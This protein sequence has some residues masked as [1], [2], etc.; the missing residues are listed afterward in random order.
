MAVSDY[1][2]QYADAG[3]QYGVDPQL[4]M[5]Q[6][7]A[8]SS[9]DINA[10]GADTKYGNAEG[11]A[12]LIPDTAKRLGVTNPKDPTQAIP[13]QAKLM[14][15][16]LDRYGNVE[17][18]LKAYHG[19][20]NQSNWGPV[21]HAYPAKVLKNY[22]G[23]QQMASND[24]ENDPL[25]QALLD[26]AEA[27]KTK[28]AG[29]N[30]PLKITIPNLKDHQENDPLTQALLDS[31]EEDKNKPPQNTNNKSKIGAA[32]DLAETIPSSVV[33]AIGAVP[34]IP[35][36]AGNTVANAAGY[37]YGKL[38]GATPEQQ[39]KLNTLNPFFTGNTPLDAL[40]QSEGAIVNNNPGPANPLTGGVLH[41]PETT[42]GRYANAL[43]QGAVIGP[44]A[45]AR[46]IPSLTGAAGAQTASEIAP[47]NPLAPLVG[48]LA[49]GVGPSASKSLEL[50]SPPEELANNALR[51]ATDQ[52]PATLAPNNLTSSE[53]VP[54]SK[55]TLAQVTND[56]N[57]AVIERQLQAKNPAAFKTVEDTNENARQQYFQHASGTPEDIEA[58]QNQREQATT[59]LYDQARI[60]PLNKEAISPILSKI[61]SAVE[62]VGDG[63]DAG[64]TLLAIKKKIEGALPSDI[65]TE[66]GT[67]TRNPTQSPLIQIYREERDN[68][69]KPSTAEGA[70]AATVKS[71][72]KPIISSLGDAIE[73]QSEPFAK[74]QQTYREISP[75]IDAAQWLQGLK[76]TD[77]TGRFT[78][79]K[80]NNALQNAQR[81]QSSNGL[82]SAKNLTSEQMTTLTN[83]RDDL[84]RRENVA[85]ASMPRG[86]N[87]AQNL[88]SSPKGG[89]SNSA[90]NLLN[91]HVPSWVG[92]SGG[93][94][95]GSMI[96]W[97][98]AGAAVGEIL[99]NALK[100][101]GQKRQAAATNALQNFVLDPET[102]KNYLMDAHKNSYLDRLKG[103]LLVKSQP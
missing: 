47:N 78:L 98:T 17:D 25:T 16:N 75:K 3:A 77:A 53:I 8:E 50:R 15:E 46:L 91:E 80:V 7:Q 82:N 100:G 42:L 4:L 20:T 84:L 54:G 93:A 37:T 73:S 97:P 69:Q 83:L 74:A 19:G 67:K 43:I 89:V 103:N 14:R 59:P 35:A 66:S 23:N 65:E 33:K 22:K 6:A 57:I 102:Y 88:L 26:S 49:G 11:I 81:L 90:A 87:T 55:P 76:L 79:A 5:A 44:A 2:Q 86:S 56:P 45:G 24:S 21:T 60:Q 62:E 71:V 63:S 72:I 1:A 94:A 39:G 101:G 95:L 64:K 38:A 99:T 52:N 58:L 92:A 13:A 28:G 40:S 51:G 18:A 10:V 85:R 70:Y 68:L 61:D 29:A 9:G 31:V 30:Q 48:G 32:Q 96:G 12:Q 27:D 34:Q 41:E 36:M